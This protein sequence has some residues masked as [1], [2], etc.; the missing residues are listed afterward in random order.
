[1]RV[2]GTARAGS[3]A[4]DAW[5][6]FAPPATNG[7][8]E[9]S[10]LPPGGDLLKASGEAFELSGLC[11]NKLAIYADEAPWL[12]SYCESKPVAKAKRLLL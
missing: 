4:S 3:L 7:L 12:T 2:P 1:M 11:G 5:T 6:G 8:T 9:S 10:T